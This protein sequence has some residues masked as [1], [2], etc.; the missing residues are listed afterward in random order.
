MLMA[1]EGV[2]VDPQLELVALTDRSWRVRDTRREMDDPACL[3]AYI[4]HDDLG[5]EVMLLRHRG[6]DIRRVDSLAEALA[7]ASLDEPAR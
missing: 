1:Y 4:E 6:T 3:I 5:F 7:L 2:P